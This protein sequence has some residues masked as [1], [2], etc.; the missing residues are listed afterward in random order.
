MIGINLED[1]HQYIR[2]TVGF[3]F[4]QGGIVPDENNASI[5]GDPNCIAGIVL[6]A[7]TRNSPIR[8][9]LK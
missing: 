5:S 7:E 6:D 2:K 3:H 8:R 1:I 4:V 9:E